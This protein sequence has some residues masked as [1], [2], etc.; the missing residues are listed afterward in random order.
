MQF[1]VFIDDINLRLERR[2]NAEWKRMND[3]RRDA[4]GGTSTEDGD[5][6][7]PGSVKMLTPIKKKRGPDLKVR[8]RR[9]GEDVTKPNHLSS[10][11]LRAEES[12]VVPLE[13][14]E[15]HVILFVLFIYQY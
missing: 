13:N 12:F 2:T 15:Y 4:I 11:F 10:E 14:G 6:L 1:S 5:M 8:K 9:I 3:A 7:S